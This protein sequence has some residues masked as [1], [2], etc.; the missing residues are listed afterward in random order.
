MSTYLH[1]RLTRT[2]LEEMASGSWRD[3]QR[4]L[5][6]RDITRRWHV[7]QPTVR[8][9]LRTL[10]GLGLL[11]ATPRSGTFLQRDFQQKAQVLLRR[12]R[13]PSVRPPLHL[14]QKA[15]LLKGVRG[16]KI[17]LLLETKSSPAQ[18][19]YTELPSG[20]GTSVRECAEAFVEEGRKHHFKVHFFLY[21]GSEPNGAWVRQRLEAGKYEGAAVFCRSSHRVVRPILEPLM[22]RHLPIVIMYDD[23][24]GLPV[25]SV[26]LNNVGVGYD[27]IRQLYEMGHRKITVLVRKAPLKLHKARLKGSLLAEAEGSCPGLRLTVLPLAFRTPPTRLVRRHFASRA[28]RPTA[29]FACESGLAEQLGPFWRQAG[30]AIPKDLSL[31]LC[32]SKTGLPG[33][34]PL[35][36]TMVLKMGRRIGRTAARQLQRIQA[37]EPL[38]KTVLLDVR[39][40]SR[41]STRTLKTT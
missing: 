39:Y 4:F 23:C 13:T 25:H 17:A 22:Q 3:G 2:L 27:A 18:E 20:L 33:F 32:S 37:G 35:L 24:Q 15:R 28:T 9:S 19:E 40:V 31:I 41:G 29:V 14:E 30:L 8:S 1:E 7:S 6:V 16:G 26:N 36:D 38:E 11:A 5:S 12:N 10:E 34:E 21:D